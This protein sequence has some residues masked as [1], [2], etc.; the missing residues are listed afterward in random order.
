MLDELVSLREKSEFLSLLDD[1]DLRSLR[2]ELVEVSVEPGESLMAV[3]EAGDHAY[4]LLEGRLATLST[5]AIGSP[6]SRSRTRT[7]A[8]RRGGGSCSIH[9]G[10][11]ETWAVLGRFGGRSLR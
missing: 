7:T 6:G 5:E 1:T 11:D 3:G 8:R 10:E 4:I 9:V 2:D